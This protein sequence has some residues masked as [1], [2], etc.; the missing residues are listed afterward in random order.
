[1]PKDTRDPKKTHGKLRYLVEAAP[2]AM[3]AEQAG[4]MAIDG[5]RRILDIEPQE[6][7]ERVPLIVGSRNE[8]S[9]VK[10]IY[11]KHSKK[12]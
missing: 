5:A 1:Y 12:A 2:M 4:G 3:I 6:L 7:H 10:E 9:M 11:A 8:V